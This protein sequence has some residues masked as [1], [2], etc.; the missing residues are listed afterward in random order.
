MITL[1]P[2]LSP[3][4]IGWGLVYPP[5]LE[6]L[7]ERAD[8]VGGR[9]I[10]AVETPHISLTL[11]TDYGPT[12]VDSVKAFRALLARHGVA[13]P[14]DATDAAAAEPSGSAAA[15]RSG[16]ALRADLLG[17]SYGTIAIAHM[18]KKSPALVRSATL[19]DPVCIGAHRATLCRRFLYEPGYPGKG[20]V[21]TVKKWLIHRDAVRPAFMQRAPPSCRG[22]RR[23]LSSLRQLSLPKIARRSYRALQPPSAAPSAGRCCRR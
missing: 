23:P 8:A 9:P 10:L 2:A 22:G 5:L 1:P 19:V 12:P 7:V 14:S 21:G 15:K 13:E 18:I 6:D 11:P 3:P 4:G 17:H 20:V 16:G